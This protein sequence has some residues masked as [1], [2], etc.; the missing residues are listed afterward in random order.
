MKGNLNQIIAEINDIPQI[1]TTLEAS[2][3]I[4]NL[5][6]LATAMS[7]LPEGGISSKLIGNI[8]TEDVSNKITDLA[9]AF[10]ILYEQIAKFAGTGEGAST[11]TGVMD[12]L[13]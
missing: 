9:A 1:T 10:E 3:L 5:S 6:N 12:S 11:F 7:Q 13:N 8:N 4:T 2:S